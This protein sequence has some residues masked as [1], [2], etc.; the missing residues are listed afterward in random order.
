MAAK[1]SNRMKKLT[2]IKQA[3]ALACVCGGLILS[4]AKVMAQG[5]RGNFDPE[6]AK[7][8]TLDRY[9]EALEISDDA[10]WKAI[11]TK[12]I[13][14]L[15][16]REEAQ[17]GGRGGFGRGGRGRG[18]NNQDAGAGG[19]GGGGRRGGGGFG[20]MW[21]GE[22]NPDIEAL[23]KA[24]EAKASPDELKAKMAK[25]RESVKAR[26]AKLVAAQDDLR[27]LL[28]VRQEATS[29]TMGLLK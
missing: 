1:R 13:A 7:Q 27:K 5:G 11:Q 17:S 4:N 18:G 24:V 26:E 16:A 19:A 10:E 8:M 14:V 3:L 25:L 29:V 2:L 20:S 22:V 6:Q 12:I 28:S 23:Q 15:K 21:G 9:K